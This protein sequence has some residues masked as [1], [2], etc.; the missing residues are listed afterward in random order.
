M[1]LHAVSSRLLGVH[2]PALELGQRAVVAN[3]SNV[4]DSLGRLLG[5][6]DGD[7]S[8]RDVEEQGER[9]S[10]SSARVKGEATREGGGRE[11]IRRE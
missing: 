10:Q 3:S 4:L 2:D 8:P 11:E 1:S 6:T 7:L 9:E 5:Q